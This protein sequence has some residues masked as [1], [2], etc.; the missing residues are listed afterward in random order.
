MEEAARLRR[1]LESTSRSCPPPLHL[2]PCAD[3]VVMSLPVYATPRPA[4]EAF[5]YRLRIYLFVVGEFQTATDA[6]MG[7]GPSWTSLSPYL[8]RPATSTQIWW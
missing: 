2:L 4:P 5:G 7:L 8:P 1:P 3:I 6:S